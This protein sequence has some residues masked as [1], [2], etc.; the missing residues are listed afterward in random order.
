MEKRKGSSGYLAHFTETLQRNGRHEGL[1]HSDD[2]ILRQSHTVP[3]R[4]LHTPRA[5][6]DGRWGLTR[7]GQSF[8]QHG[9]AFPALG[10]TQIGKDRTS[11]FIQ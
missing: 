6:S 11:G 10:K 7:G 5:E 2:L 9:N 1:F 4:R 8:Q 3:D